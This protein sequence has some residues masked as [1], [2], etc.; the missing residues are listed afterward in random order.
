MAFFQ[1]PQNM[2]NVVKLM[3]AGKRTALPSK[4]LVTVEQIAAFAHAPL[5]SREVERS[6]FRY[7]D[8][9]RDKRRRQTMETLKH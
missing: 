7:E 3:I 5:S 9:P 2:N 1:R 4:K 6:F 8:V